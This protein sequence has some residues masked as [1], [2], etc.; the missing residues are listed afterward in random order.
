VSELLLFLGL[1]VL[2]AAFLSFRQ[3]W[4]RRFGVWMV[5]VTSFAAGYLPTGKVWVGVAVASLWLFVPWIEILLRVRHLRLPLRRKLRQFPPP[6]REVFPTLEE[7]SEQ[8]E[9]AGF[10]HV[11]DTGWEMEE[12]RQFLRLYARP[13]GREEAVITC[14]QQNELGFAFISITSRGNDGT[15]YTTWNCPLTASLQM[16]P[17][18]HLQRLG[19]DVSFEKLLAAH[20]AFVRQ[21][22]L[23]WEQL[24]PVDLD[25]VHA[26][27]ERD[28]EVQMQHNLS[29]GV[30]RPLD[31]CHGGYSWKGMLFLWGRVLKELFV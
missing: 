11:A 26:A 2:T 9:S 13:S 21:H 23:T 25:S 7:D 8:I 18:L 4:L 3:I 29:V 5:G 20:G 31:D 14:V 16:P 15:V 30:L 27:V 19:E 28:M 6:S 12:Y 1:A 17:T 10:E 22:G 24:S